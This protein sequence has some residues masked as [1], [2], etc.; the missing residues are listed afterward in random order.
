MSTRRVTKQQFADGTTI[1]GNRIE[2]ALRDIEEIADRVPAGLIANRFTQTQISMGF[3]PVL[4]GAANWKQPWMT[5]QNSIA[6]EAENT[7]RVKGSGAVTHANPYDVSDW[8]L[9][10]VSLQRSH[11]VILDSF[12]LFMVQDPGGSGGQ[13]YYMPGGSPSPYIPPNVRDLQMFVLVDNPFLPED[14]AQAS[15]VVHKADFD[16]DAWLFTPNPSAPVVSDMLPPHPGGSISGWSVRISNL[17]VPLA[18]YSRVRFVIA[19]PQY[20]SP[21]PGQTNWGLQPWRT[22]APSASVTLLEPNTDG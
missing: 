7:F 15:M 5:F 16:S 12:D 4:S 21:G 1:D 9:W 14:R 8:S 22:F 19:I 20:D 13:A 6:S 10:E 17:R 3:Q 11:P 2:V 18:P